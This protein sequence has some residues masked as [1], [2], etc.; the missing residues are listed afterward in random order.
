MPI[1]LN[2]T[3]VNV[4]S[5]RDSARFFTEL[6]GLPA[7]RR[8]GSYFHHHRAL[9]RLAEEIDTDMAAPETDIV[10]PAKAEVHDFSIR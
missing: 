3:I 4:P 5:K 2:H 1:K 9:R 6:F 8:V 7:P 10:A